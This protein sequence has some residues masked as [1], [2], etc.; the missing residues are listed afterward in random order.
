MMMRTALFSRALLL[1]VALALPAAAAPPSPQHEAEFKRLAAQIAGQRQSGQEENA[2][3]FEYSLSLLDQMVLATLNVTGT[4]NLEVINTQ[5]GLLV[6][7]QP[8]VG[9]EYKV[10]RL[11]GKPPAFALVA[12][13]GVSGPSTVRLYSASGGPRFRL[14]ARIDRFTQ[15]EFFDDY[16][17]LISVEAA[18]PM[19]VTVTG[20]TD[21]LKSG[22]FTAWRLS[23]EKLSTVWSTDIL[24]Q[25]SYEPTPAGIHL[26]YCA[27]YAE[28]HPQECRRMSSERFAWDGAVW[29]RVEQQNIT[30][31][32]PKK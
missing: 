29:Q 7:N 4:P 11:G 3:L 2:Q 23:D 9:E 31:A 16:L 8:A 21:A 12:N 10:Y 18:E 17:A 13:F 32:P 27:D 22:A 24:P 25:S 6:E 19:F 30:P 28:D 5:L 26:T 14:I 20:R 15:K 1:A